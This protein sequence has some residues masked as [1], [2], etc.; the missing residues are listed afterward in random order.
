MVQVRNCRLVGLLDLNQGHDFV[1]QKVVEYMNSLIDMGVVGF[2]FIKIFQ[3]GQ[4][5][6]I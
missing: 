3:I 4:E 6:A 5:F 1:R 2:R